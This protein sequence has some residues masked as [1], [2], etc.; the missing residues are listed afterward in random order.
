MNAG[1]PAPSPVAA[2]L[3][4]P[5]TN[6]V[7]LRPDTLAD[8]K[9][10]PRRRLSLVCAPAGY[11]K[12]TV[13]AAAVERLGLEIIWY[14]L[15]ALDRDPVVFLANLTEALRERFAEF[16]DAIRERLRTTAETPFPIEHMQALF[17]TECERKV[18]RDIHFVLDDY[19]EAAESTE[20]N[21]ALDYLLAN[22][23]ASLR[24][25]VLTRYDPAF[26]VNRMRLAGDVAAISAEALR[27]DTAQAMEVLAARTGHQ[28]RRTHIEQLVALTEGWPAS[29]VLAGLALEWLDLGSLELTLSDPRLKQDIYSYL[30]EQVYRHEDDAV[31]SFLKRTCCLENITAGL[32]NRLAGTD[33]AHRYL[34]HLAA[35][36]VFTFATGEEGAYRY[37]NLFR[38]F[39]KQRCLREEGEPAFRR[40]QHETAAALEDV[41]ETEM[42][43]ELYLNANQPLDALGVVARGGEAGLEGLPSE[44]LRSWRD[45]LPAEAG[46]GAPWARLIAG[47][48]R[49]RDGDYHEALREIDQAVHAF[50]DAADEWGLY[51]AL[52]MRE[53]ALF[54]QGDTGAALRTCEA[55]LAHAQTDQQKTHT[56]LS[57]GSA[58]LDM[59]HWQEAEAAFAAADAVADG[60]TP[61]EQI[62][63][64][65]LRA[66][67]AY[68]RGD[69]RAAR[70]ALPTPQPADTSGAVRAT[71]LNS[72]GI[73]ALGLADYAQA[74]ALFEEA[75]SV[76]ERFGY[77]PTANMVHD[78]IGLL[79]GAQG[80][81]TEG[82]MIVR[83]TME[84]PAFTAEPTHEASMLS[85][86]ATL[87][88]RAGDL[89]AALAPCTK[90]AESV[91]FERDPYI[92]LNSQAN[93]LYLRALLGGKDAA[94][95]LAVSERAS[96]AGLSFVALKARLYAAIVAGT[97]GDV[98]VCVELLRDCLPRQL[99]LGH[100]HLL[101]QELCP[102]PAL[103]ALALAS[104]SPD[105]AQRLMGALASH[106]GF[107]ELVE[108]LVAD[109]PALAAAAV[110]AAAE[111]ASDE[112][113]VRVL[114]VTQGI[115]NG[116]LARAVETALKQRP[117]V[118]FVAAPVFPELTRR[119]RQVLRL[120]AEGL[121]NQEIADQLF[122]ALSTVK[123]HVNHVLTKL[124]VRTRVEAILAFK[125]ATGHASDRA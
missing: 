58:A 98:A 119:E 23:P 22:L 102:R 45:R 69:F 99:E 16:G 89:E 124:G 21:R 7:V 86:E 80:Y 36:R 105:L 72:G 50:E 113:L 91:A 74:L 70:A 6:G 4:R 53:C 5:S 57:L 87:L 19:H 88:R 35:N 112:V 2:K 97:A 73:V 39:L 41:G 51:H 54:W 1:S 92:A 100:L 17:V 32:A 81:V 66:H 96:G 60:A 77:T 85:H 115:R 95:L 75:R 114:A 55:A 52:S 67:A 82:L 40:L 76:A 71:I 68:Y 48:L 42:A 109:S 79:R 94:R 106:W 10:A 121:R 15:D 33:A 117:G 108:A 123:T 107:A 34:A 111:R 122:L 20:L 65:A 101:A 43:V 12:T 27:F 93:L 90:A 104:A 8:F 125:E 49:S 38:D 118:S 103:A 26:S 37:H 9:R 62:R 44:R 110:R 29:V 28:P 31:R 3:A 25:I 14:K 120:M 116:A 24:F 13:A 18:E 47:Q 11:G 30:A 46:G 64:R 56:L 84:V 63:A 59:R 83:Q 78:N 61:A